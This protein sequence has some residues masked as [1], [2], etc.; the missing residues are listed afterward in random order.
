[1]EENKNQLENT[2]HGMKENSVAPETPFHES[3]PGERDQGR[4][5]R[6]LMVSIVE[7]ERHIR[8]RTMDH[9][10]SGTVH[11]LRWAIGC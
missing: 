10:E 5:L 7:K 2:D 11:R 4:I 8:H 3:E 9:R 1:M 6:I